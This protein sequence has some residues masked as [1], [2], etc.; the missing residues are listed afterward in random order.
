MERALKGI[1]APQGPA[2]LLVVD[3]EAAIGDLVA[4]IFAAEGMEVRACTSGADA[5]E[6]LREEEFDLAIL[7]IMMP[8][9]DGFELC[10]RLRGLSEMPVVFLSAKDDETDVVVGFA[11]GADDYV[12]KPFKPRELVARVKARLRRREAPADAGA[13]AG[14]LEVRG[15]EVDRR[16]HTAALHDVPLALTPK[17]FAMLALLVEHAGEPVSARELYEGAWDEAYEASCA[18]TVMV[19]IRHLRQK[20][21]EVDS[22][23]AFIE[24]AWGVG[25]RVPLGAKGAG[26]DGQGA[27]R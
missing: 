15:I 24:T 26:A 7:D 17:E 23:T 22:S 14:A 25:Y 13:S 6:L 4:G 3:D 20:L 11:L 8:E 2:R 10:R 16:S 1:A 19:H 5:L 9:I 27:C 21:A 18:N 12:S